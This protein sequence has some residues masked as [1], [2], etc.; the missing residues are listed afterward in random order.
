MIRKVVAS[1]A[2]PVVAGMDVAV[3]EHGRIRA[4]Y[5]FLDKPAGD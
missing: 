5:T 3:F 1:E 4:L 2:P